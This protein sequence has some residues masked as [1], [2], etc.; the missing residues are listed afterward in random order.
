MTF[1][2]I[3]AVPAILALVIWALTD[4]ESFVLVAVLGAIVFPASLAKPGGSNIDGADLLLLVA[5]AAWLI[6]NSARP[7]SGSLDQRQC[8]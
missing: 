2:L 4:L 5:L 8:R 3:A 6:S 1:L 7:S